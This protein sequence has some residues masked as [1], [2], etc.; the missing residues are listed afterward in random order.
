MSESKKIKYLSK[1]VAFNG[2]T[3]TLFSIDGQTWSSRKQELLEIK[4]RQ[5]RDKVS[6]VAI[7]EENGETRVAPKAKGKIAATVE[8]E[9]EAVVLE[10]AAE[11]PIVDYSTD[12]EK[13]PKKGK[14]GPKFVAKV[15]EIKPQKK[16]FKE[17]P[18]SK[19]S[20]KEKAKKKDLKIVPKKRITGKPKVK[21]S[22]KSK[23]RAA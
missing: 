10:E 23:R 7:K 6:F 20:D 11:F 3:L 16:P 2:K 4:E 22:K 13:M 8:D 5:E 1:S 15:K 18:L 19:K 12:E 14:R 9:E 21:A 17:V